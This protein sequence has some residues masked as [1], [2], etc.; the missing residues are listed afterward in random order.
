[1]R[2][3]LTPHVVQVSSEARLADVTLLIAKKSASHCIVLE[4]PEGLYLGVVRISDALTKPSGRI[5]AD[6]I[7]S[8]PAYRVARNLSR[9]SLL[10]IV[11]RDKLEEA[12][13][14]SN[15]GKF[16]G[17]ITP[18]SLRQGHVSDGSEIAGLGPPPSSTGAAAVAKLERKVRKQALDLKQAI[19]LLDDFSYAVSHD[20]R[21][22]LRAIRG[23]ALALLE[24]YGP[25]LD[26]AAI[27]YVQRT[28]RAS[29]RLDR[30]T[31]GVLAYV[32]ISRSQPSLR[33]LN[34][35][36]VLAEVIEAKR[37][38]SPKAE[39]QVEK[40]LGTVRAD[41]A[42]L[43]LCLSQIIDNA[44]KFTSPGQTPL[45]KIGVENAGRNDRLFIE[46]NGIGI[47]P[48]NR[49]RVF[50][51]FEQLNPEEVFD[52]AGVGLALVHKAMEKMGGMV[53]IGA[54]QKGCRFWLQFSG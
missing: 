51:L 3:L 47:G 21:T 8:V 28:I 34:L 16:I 11:H 52:G 35:S 24:D 14:L 6:L 49:R 54:G 45:I 42:L 13:V 50:K 30:L 23:Y 46:D 41:R 39:I 19:G 18:E 53:G 20:I 7:S 33:K 15:T 44:L 36:R 17:L 48:E 1:M 12:V 37:I 40:R 43:V 31:I 2:S 4:Q 26:E 5:F 10:D 38:I 32:E 29:H 27:T 9:S 22:P 25:H